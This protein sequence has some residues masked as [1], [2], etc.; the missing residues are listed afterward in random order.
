MRVL[1]YLFR[2][3]G[4]VLACVLLWVGQATAQTS[5]Q[6]SEPELKAAIIANML[7][8]VE[9]PSESALR[10]DLLRVC[11]SS[12][13]PVASAL[14]RL[15]G[16]TIKGK[17]LRVTQTNVENLSACHAYYFSPADG[18]ALAKTVGEARPTA[19]LLTGDSPEYLE[20]GIMINLELVSERIV[21]DIDLR[22]T[23]KAG[24][25]VSSK[26]LRLA[27]QVIE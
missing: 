10:S 12:S 24:L 21:F 26:A 25:R 8:F 7:L 17:T 15:D 13:S 22:P 27:R 4:A 6:A 9:W 11:Y 2:H 14:A 16:K 19:V 3:A 23:Q 18:A 20:R 1:P 5:P